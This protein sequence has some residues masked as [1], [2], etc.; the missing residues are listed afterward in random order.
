MTACCHS[1]EIEI[2]HMVNAKYHRAEMLRFQKL[3]TRSCRLV[4]GSVEAIA[5]TMQKDEVDEETYHEAVQSPCVPGSA[6]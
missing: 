1:M 2:R 3:D 4:L 6:I 5:E